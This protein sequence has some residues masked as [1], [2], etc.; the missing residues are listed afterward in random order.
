MF[1]TIHYKAQCP[2]CKAD[3]EEW[4]SKD[5]P[6]TLDVIEPWQVRRMYTFCPSCNVW[7]DARVKAEVVVTKLEVEIEAEVRA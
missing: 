6:C 4:Q 3:V 2:A 5:G 7:L 1:D